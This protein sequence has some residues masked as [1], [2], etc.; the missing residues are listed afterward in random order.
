ML[1]ILTRVLGT[2]HERDVKRMW[3]IVTQI[4]A[5]FER[6]REFDDDTLRAK[7]AEFRA[8]LQ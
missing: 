7:S 6:L 8:R 3:P 1:N 5:E 2:K 4:N